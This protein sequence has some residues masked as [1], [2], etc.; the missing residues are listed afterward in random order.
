[1]TGKEGAGA[2]E[3]GDT[4]E[5]NNEEESEDRRMDRKRH[6]RTGR[7]QQ[8]YTDEELVKAVEKLEIA[9]T[10]EVADEVDGHHNHVR[11]RLKELEENGKIISKMKSRTIIWLPP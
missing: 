8:E 3:G 5:E 4:V 11:R 10:T 1:M 9:T 6:R 2:T 7:Y